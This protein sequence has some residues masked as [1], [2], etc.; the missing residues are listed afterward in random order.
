M[1]NNIMPLSLWSEDDGK[2]VFI[3]KQYYTLTVEQYVKAKDRDD[4]FDVWLNN[5]GIINDKITRHL[6]QE[7]FNECETSF[8]D[9]DTPDTKVEYVG[10]ITRLSKDDPYELECNT[11]VPEVEDDNKVVPFNKKVE[12]HA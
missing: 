9:T 10:T 3:V 1:N 2:K 5:G 12:E 6:T 7:S 8:I 4:A 11:D